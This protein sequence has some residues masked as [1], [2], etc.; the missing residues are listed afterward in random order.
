[1]ANSDTQNTLAAIE[2]G[3]L[4]TSVVVATMP[5]FL[6]KTRLMLQCER[7]TS[8]TSNFKNCV[9]EIYEEHGIKGFYKGLTLSLLL[10]SS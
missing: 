3:I 7:S 5:F 6:I 2:S 10:S 9:K 1:M 4:S 8:G